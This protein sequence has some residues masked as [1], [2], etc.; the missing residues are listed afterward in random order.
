MI[1]LSLKM[2]KTLWKLL[3]FSVGWVF[4]THTCMYDLSDFMMYGQYQVTIIKYMFHCIIGMK[5]PLLQW[6][7]KVSPWMFSATMHQHLWM[8]LKDYK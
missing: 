5:K 8:M 6:P 4:T 2:M 7:N 3:L 1:Y